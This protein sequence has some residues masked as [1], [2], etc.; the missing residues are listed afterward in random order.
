ML[1]RSPAVYYQFANAAYEKISGGDRVQESQIGD[2]LFRETLLSRTAVVLTVEVRDGTGRTG[3]DKEETDFLEADQNEKNASWADNTAKEN[4]LEGSVSENVIPEKEISGSGI[5]TVIL[6]VNGQNYDPVRKPEEENGE[7]RYCFQL[8]VLPGQETAYHPETL[9]I[10]D[11]AGN[12]TVYR[13]GADLAPETIAVDG[14][15]PEV[16]FL[17][18]A[19]SAKNREGVLEWYSASARGQALRITANARDRHG[20]YSM[21]WY[22]TDEEGKVIQGPLDRKSTRLNS[23]H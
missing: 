17:D 21:E 16:D 13:F 10:T 4:D 7:G 6:K 2:Y 9:E 1:F 19:Y 20:I 18:E 15:V 3:T 8:P 5:E 12:R 14:K 23:S 11:R 22:M